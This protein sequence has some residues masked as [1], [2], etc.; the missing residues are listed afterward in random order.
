MQLSGLLRA[1]VCALGISTARAI[2]NPAGT[3]VSVWSKNPDLS[4]R[5]V[6]RLI[7]RSLSEVSHQKRETVFSN[8]TSFEQSWDGAVLLSL[9]Y[10][11]T[12]QTSQGELERTVKVDVSCTTCYLKAQ[13][14]AELTIDRPFNLTETFNNFTDQVGTQVG[15]VSDVAVEYVRNYTNGVARNLADG[16]DLDDLDLPP[17]DIDFNIDIPQ[18]PECT[19]RFQFDELELY[20][21]LNT[22]FSAGITYTLNLYASKTQFGVQISPRLFFGAVV[23]VDL[24]LSAEAEISITSGFHIRIDDGAELKL[25]LFAD[26]VAES[27]IGGQFEFLPVIVESAGVLLKAVLR[28]KLRTGFEIATPEIEILGFNVAGALDASAGVEVSVWTHIAELSTNVTILPAG[29]ETDGCQLR[30]EEGY[31]FGIGAAAGATVALLDHT[32]GPAP[33]TTIP[34]YF[35]TFTQCAIQTTPPSSTITSSAT[36]AP[37]QVSDDG[38]LTSSTSNSLT[39]T[40]ITT[41]VTYRGIECMSYDMV[42]CPVSLQRTTKTESRI[43]LVTSVPSG[44]EATFPV[45]MQ[46]TGVQPISFGTGV[47]KLF[48]TSGPPTAYTPSA[49]PESRIGFLEGNI[50]GVDKRIILG[51]SIG[52]GLLVLGIIIGGIIICIRRRKYSAVP[53]PAHGQ[54]TTSY[55]SDHEP[56]RPGFVKYDSE[57][58]VSTATTGTRR[59]S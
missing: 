48:E 42:D 55:R 3:D 17:L 1:V 26:E 35:T 28:I 45:T 14:L 59:G 2:S 41:I 10:T 53:P 36:I 19:L 8:S 51:V 43:T 49:T 37:R 18:I 29:D 12:T 54:V 50:G 16:F 44:V 40:T 32:W 25:G 56:Y 30:V 27:D 21:E 11:A 22:V 33:S 5:D 58:T 9:E 20:V 4:P 15:N 23:V 7:G 57:Q 34:I 47:Q 31:Q 24:I 46:T 52:G 39:T 6:M 38:T 13:V